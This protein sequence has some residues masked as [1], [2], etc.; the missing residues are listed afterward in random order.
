MTNRES[1]VMS[2]RLDKMMNIVDSLTIGDLTSSTVKLRV[3]NKIYNL[4]PSDD[5]TTID[6]DQIRSEYEVKWIEK[7]NKIKEKIKQQMDEISSVVST[8]DA[9][10]KRKELMLRNQ[11]ANSAP[12]PDVNLSHAARGLSIVKGTSLGE[13]IWLVRRTYSPRFLDHKMISPTYVKKLLTNIYIKIVTKHMAITS[14]STHYIS[15]L[16][17]FDHYHRNCWGSWI[18]PTTWETADD[19]LK[20]ADDAISVLDNINTMSIARRNP[21][22]LPR[23]DTLRR[24]TT[25]VTAPVQSVTVSTTN[26]RQGIGV[27]IPSDDIWQN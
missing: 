19:I 23:L 8:W 1:S 9:E 6:E 26:L 13:V 21:R 15:N 17:P 7:S 4:T 18:V 27:D 12:M 2:E 24:H 22:L 25:D 20:T 5:I 11:M 16:E 14:V 3:G 10:Y